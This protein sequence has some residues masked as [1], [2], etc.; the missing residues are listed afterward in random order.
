MNIFKG[1]KKQQICFD[2]MGERSM[3]PIVNVGDEKQEDC[4][5]QTDR[6]FSR[7]LP[8]IFCLPCLRWK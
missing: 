3:I 5:G 8:P 4:A 7:Q 6:Q 2:Q 1:K